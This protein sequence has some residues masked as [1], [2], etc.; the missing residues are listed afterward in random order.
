MTSNRRIKAL[1]TK[2]KDTTFRSR[3]EARYACF[4]D[5]LGIEWVY[6]KEGYDLGDGVWYLPD[7]YLPQFGGG[8][9]VEVKYQGGDMSKAY[10][11]VVATGN[12]IWLCEGMPSAKRYAIVTKVEGMDCFEIFFLR[13]GQNVMMSVSVVSDI[14]YPMF[15]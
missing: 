12:D 11:F 10:K 14:Q 5:H 8:V 1:P 13:L 7:F 4:F 15:L 6:E 3:L 9:H 2:Y